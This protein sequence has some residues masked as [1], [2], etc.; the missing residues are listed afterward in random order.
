MDVKDLLRVFGRGFWMILGSALVGGMAV[1][2]VS[3]RTPPTYEASATL[4]IHQPPASYTAT[5]YNSIFTTDSLSRTIADILPSRQLLQDVIDNL[6]LGIE[7]RSLAKR[8]SVSVDRETQIVVI[9]VD[10]SD[11]R[12]AAAIAN[13]IIRVFDTHNRDLQAQAFA[14]TRRTLQQQLALAQAE[15]DRAQAGIDAARGAEPS[16]EVNRLQNLLE[17][18]QSNYQTIHLSMDKLELAESQ[19]TNVVSVVDPA[20]PPLTPVRPR[21]LLNG[22]LAAIIG[23]LLATGAVTVLDF[24][25]DSLRSGG[26]AERRLGVPILGSV[27]RARGLGLHGA[28]ITADDP[29]SP[30]AESYRLVAGRIATSRAAGLPSTIT[31]TGPGPEA[32]RSAIVANLAVALAQIGKRVIVVD[33]NLRNPQ[34]YGY[35]QPSNIYGDMR[36][37]PVEGDWSPDDHL[38]PTRI[39][40]VYL[41]SSGP[42]PQQAPRLLGVQ[43]VRDLIRKLHAHADVVI[44]DSPPVLE[45]VDTTLLANASHAT[46]LLATIGST[47]MSELAAAHDHLIR[48]QAQILGVIVSERS[49]LAIPTFVRAT[50]SGQFGVRAPWLARFGPS[51]LRRRSRPRHPAEDVAR[52]R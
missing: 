9:T 43:P 40:N 32:G 38:E 44:F 7:A 30:V 15:I 41:L 12:R 2:A 10:D 1:F 47:K 49:D 29:R 24:L 17:Q 13:E 20:H 11:P 18:Y 27:P 48:A 33:A 19:S 51:G 25:D 36:V 39:D 52:A 3:Q 22:I 4:L 31:V 23:A 37:L 50:R 14:A 46:V 6:H 45:A 34:L 21:P 26:D 35:F 42:L 16:A 5:G 28:I 8:V